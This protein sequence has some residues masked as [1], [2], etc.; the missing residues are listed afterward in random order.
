MRLFGTLL[1]MNIEF[2]F[3]KRN[4]GDKFSAKIEVNGQIKTNMTAATA[5]TRES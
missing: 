5:T 3:K 4:F 2:Y 1:L